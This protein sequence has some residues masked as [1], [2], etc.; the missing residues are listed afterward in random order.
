MKS[1]IVLALA[2]ACALADDA[3]PASKPVTSQPASAPAARFQ[4]VKDSK[5]GFIDSRGKIVVEP[6]SVL[7]AR[8][9]MDDYSEGLARFSVGGKCGFVDTAG[10]Q[11]IEPKFDFADNFHEG[12]AAVQ[13]GTKFGFIDRTGKMVI[14]AQFGGA[15]HFGDGLAPVWQGQK[16]GSPKFGLVNAKGQIVLPPV[17]YDEILP[18]GQGL[19]RCRKDGLWG[20]LDK[21]GAVAIKPQFEAAEDFF[22]GFAAVQSKG[23]WGHIDRK[24]VCAVGF[25]YDSAARFSDGLAWAMLGK[26]PGYVDT[27]GKMVVKLPADATGWRRFSEGLAPVRTMALWGYIDRTGKFVMEPKWID[28]YPFDHGLARVGVSV[29][30]N[31]G[32]LKAGYIDHKGKYVYEPTE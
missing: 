15:W 8:Q 18:F 28:A 27:Q 7:G 4:I 9:W 26:Q 14:P 17:Y 12:L 11:V 20:Y 2:A 31:G 1:L 10:V 25:K 6:R 16:T 19:A 32:I 29:N 21:T 23:K 24:G 5:V 13:I 30:P 3:G 22:E